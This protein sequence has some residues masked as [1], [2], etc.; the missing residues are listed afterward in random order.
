[1]FSVCPSSV[2]R[3]VRRI[4]SNALPRTRPPLSEVSITPCTRPPFGA[5]IHEPSEMGSA[6]VAVNE[7]PAAAVALERSEVVRTTIFVPA[8]RVAARNGGGAGGLVC[9]TRGVSPTRVSAGGCRSTS[10][11]DAVGGG[12][13]AGGVVLADVLS[14][15]RRRG[16]SAVFSAVCAG[17]DGGTGASCCEGGAS[18]DF[19]TGSCGYGLPV[20]SN[21]NRA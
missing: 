8:S 17:S 1:M 19:S 16:R 21:G 20:A 11:A 2:S 7:S 6:R 13:S 5:M 9:T 12:A 18:R 15:G 14:R 3:L 4:V 10:G